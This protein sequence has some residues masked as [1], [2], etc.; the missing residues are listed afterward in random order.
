MFRP[1]ATGPGCLPSCHVFLYA[2]VTGFIGLLLPG[3]GGMIACPGFMRALLSMA[4]SPFIQFWVLFIA[5]WG[6]SLCV[7]NRASKPAGDVEGLCDDGQ[8]IWIGRTCFPT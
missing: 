8:G 6:V 5:V 1:A 4:C 3:V 2:D 7:V